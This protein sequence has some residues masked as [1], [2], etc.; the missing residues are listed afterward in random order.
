MKT[1][2][3][4]T[5]AIAT[6]ALASSVHSETSGIDDNGPREK[7]HD[8]PGRELLLR[9]FDKDGDGK[10]SEGERAELKKQMIQRKEERQTRMLQRFDTDKDG[11]L[12]AEE[13]K[14]TFPVIAKENKEIH[15]AIRSEFDKDGDGKISPEEAQG[16]REWVQKNH[17]DAIMMRPKAMR[18]C[19]CGKTGKKGPKVSPLARPKNLDQSEAQ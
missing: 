5:S 6:I 14:A 19:K 16:I 1:N 3:M 4:I 15:Q 18:G 9:Q 7:R 17:P 8:G 13:K 2:K 11:K 12:S 10:L